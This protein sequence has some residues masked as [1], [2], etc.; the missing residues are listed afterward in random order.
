MNLEFGLILGGEDEVNWC[1]LLRASDLRHCAQ[2]FSY[3]A[4]LIEALCSCRS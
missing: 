4:Y 1:V 3:F 2:S